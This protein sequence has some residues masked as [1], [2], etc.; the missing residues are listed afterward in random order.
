MQ[1]AK[2]C[3]VGVLAAMVLE[4]LDVNAGGIFFAKALDELDFGV[5]AVIVVNEA[6]DKA[7]DNDGWSGRNACRGSWE[8]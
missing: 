6:A 7:N 8:L 3:L 4:H 5:D 1:K 2:D